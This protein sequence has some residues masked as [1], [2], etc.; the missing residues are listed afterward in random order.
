MKSKILV[1]GHN[2]ML[3]HMVNKYLTDKDYDVSVLSSRWPDNKNSIVSFEGQ[4]IINCIGS[5]PQKK[6]VSYDI[7]WNLP[8]WLDLNSPCNVIHPGTDCEM[9]SDDYGISKN[10]AANYIRNLAKKTKSLKTSIV[11]PEIKG[12]S[13]LLEWFLSQE[14]E[15]FGYTKAIWN[16]NTTLEWAKQ[17]EFIIQNWDNYKRETTIH[18]DRVSKY[19]LLNIFKSVFDKDIIIKPKELG[20]DKSLE[21]T[22]NTKNI[23]DQLIELKNYYYR[24]GE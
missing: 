18:S 14:N 10:I 2:G 24:N 4:Y 19:E 13:S 9:D 23:S 6:K 3:G 15:V 5:I 16:G 1:L 11:G 7:N 21:G 12:K 8:I 20:T 22:I 17:C